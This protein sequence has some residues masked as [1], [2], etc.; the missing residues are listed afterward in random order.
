MLECCY[1]VSSMLTVGYAECHK[2]A[3]HAECHYAEYHYADCR[4]V[5][6]HGSP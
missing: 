1:T 3:L 4:Y 6:C 2:L 5:E